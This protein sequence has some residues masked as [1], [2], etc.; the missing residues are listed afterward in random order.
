MVLAPSIA[1][2]AMNGLRHGFS[3][4]EKTALGVLWLVPLVARAVTGATLVPVALIAMIAVFGLLIR[5]A[6][7]GRRSLLGTRIE[8]SDTTR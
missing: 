2:L 3:P 4:W 5:R 1:F 6:V 7:P 8:S